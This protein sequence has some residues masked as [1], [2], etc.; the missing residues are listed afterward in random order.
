MRQIFVCAVLFLAGA[1]AFGQPGAIYSA[2]A[3]ADLSKRLGRLEKEIP[4]AVLEAV[5][6]ASESQL[7]SFLTG[8]MSWRLWN[9]GALGGSRFVAH[10]ERH[11]IAHPERSWLILSAYRRHV[12]G[13][14]SD[15]GSLTAQALAR[16]RR[17]EER[18]PERRT[19]ESAAGRVLTRDE[20]T[21][22]DEFSFAPGRA[23]LDDDGKALLD[24]VAGLFASSV[25]LLELRGRA[26]PGEPSSVNSGFV[27]RKRFGRS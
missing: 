20:L 24:A 14:A 11:G 23:T 6:A 19:R 22:F 16:K 13:E 5:L 8:D 17:R 9:A 26:A 7:D 27:G 10:L 25:A 12:G 15:L 21:I 2:A 18:A 3:E 1:R 4:Q